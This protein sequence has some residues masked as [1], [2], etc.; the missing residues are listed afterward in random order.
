MMA[1]SKTTAAMEAAPAV[2]AV[3]EMKTIS[4][5]VTRVHPVIPRMTTQAL[6]M[7]KILEAPVLDMPDRH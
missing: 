2:T 3:L 1:V 7:R 4:G 6:G 5:S